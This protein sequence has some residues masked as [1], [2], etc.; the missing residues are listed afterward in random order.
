MCD[1]F[2]GLVLISI[3]IIIEFTGLWLKWY[4]VSRETTTI[5]I[6][7]SSELFSEISI[8]IK[9][10]MPIL[11]AFQYFTLFCFCV[12]DY[13]F[14]ILHNMSKGCCINLQIIQHLWKKHHLYKT[15]NDFLS[16]KWHYRVSVSTAHSEIGKYLYRS[17]V[18]SHL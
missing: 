4:P 14:I 2:L 12:I 6:A 18:L 1:H 10:L 3:N 9:N 17:A 16:L 13:I 8:S 5:Q 15:T 11:C 7:R